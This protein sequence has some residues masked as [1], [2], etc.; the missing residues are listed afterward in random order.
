MRAAT[1]AA[2]VSE[3]PVKLT[4]E[5]RLDK[6]KRWNSLL[7]SRNVLQDREDLSGV[8]KI[9]E[10]R[11]VTDVSVTR[12]IAR[13]PAFCRYSYIFTR[14]YCCKKVDKSRCD[15]GKADSSLTCSKNA[16][17]SCRTGAGWLRCAAGDD[18]AGARAAGRRQAQAGRQGE[19][20][21]SRRPDDCARQETRAWGSFVLSATAV[22]LVR[23]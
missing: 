10:D 22:H 11:A 13:S 1:A 14:R 5:V 23:F 19:A 9:K 12:S 17:S 7:N 6:V 16:L 15:C 21:R 2:G 4:D 18:D 20:A 3:T 8:E